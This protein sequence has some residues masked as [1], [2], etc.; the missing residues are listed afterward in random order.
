MKQ[1]E[2]MM[3]TDFQTVEARGACYYYAASLRVTATQRQPGRAENEPGGPRER[4]VPDLRLIPKSK[5]LGCG[6]ALGSWGHWRGQALRVGG[7]VGVG[8]RTLQLLTWE[9]VVSAA[10]HV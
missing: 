2:I 9:P 5:V 8:R 3:E 4:W 6:E 7:V 1:K 10:L